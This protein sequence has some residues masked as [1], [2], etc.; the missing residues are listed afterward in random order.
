MTISQNKLEFRFTLPI[1]DS[2]MCGL[3]GLLTCLP[4]NFG[5]VAEWST[6]SLKVIL[7]AE[8]K[9][10][11]PQGE[12]RSDESTRSPA[13]GVRANAFQGQSLSLSRWM[14]LGKN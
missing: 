8:A 10:K 7:D 14:D 5:E 3:S 9:R 2:N 12:E 13:K 6:K 11:R 4:P 1:S